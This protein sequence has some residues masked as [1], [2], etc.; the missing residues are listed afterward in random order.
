MVMKNS[1]LLHFCLP[2]SRST[3]TQITL[4]NTLKEIKISHLLDISPPVVILLPSKMHKVLL[5]YSPTHAL[6]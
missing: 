1:V 2:T 6:V 5:R 3:L 4:P